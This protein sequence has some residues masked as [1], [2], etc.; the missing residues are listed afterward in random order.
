MKR[1]LRYCYGFRRT[2]LSIV[3]FDSINNFQGLEN[4]SRQTSTST[5]LA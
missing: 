5:E 1:D 4:L 2:S 3:Q